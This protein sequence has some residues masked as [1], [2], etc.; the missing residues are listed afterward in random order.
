MQYKLY[1]AQITRDFDGKCSVKLRLVRELLAWQYAS[2]V[3]CALVSHTNKLTE[4]C[5]SASGKDQGF[6]HLEILWKA[7]EIRKV[8]HYCIG[9]RI[10]DV[11]KIKPRTL[12]L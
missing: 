3:K 2:H 7:K 6:D 5:Q 10:F 8:R 9:S 12:S 11:Q 4:L 1:D